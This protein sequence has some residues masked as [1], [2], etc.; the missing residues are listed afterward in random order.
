[1]PDTDAPVKVIVI[2]LEECPEVISRAPNYVGIW[3]LVREHG[4]PRGL[5]TLPFNGRD[6]TRRDVEEA[7]SALPRTEAK[8]FER[9]ADEQLPRISVV[10]PSLLRRP[11]TLQACLDSLEKLQYPD[12]EV[13]V[14]DNRPAGSPSVDDLPGARVVRQPQTGNSAARNRGLAAATGEI[15][16]F[17]DDDIEVDPNWLL[18]IA[19]RF[20]AH[21][22]EACVTGLLL[23]L[24]LESP[25][26]LMLEAYYGGL[27]PRTYEPVSHRLRV[28]PARRKLLGPA[29]VDAVGDDGRVRRS[30]SLYA[31]G[32]FGTGPN[33]AFRT[34]ALRELGGFNEAL[35]AG[36]PARGGGDLLTMARAVWAGYSIG[37]EPAA[38]VLH[39]HYAD[40]SALLRQI[41]S[42]GMGWSALVFA[43]VLEDPRHLGALL[44]TAPRAT[45]IL[46][47]RYRRKLDRQ[48][49]DP[50]T[51]DLARAELKAFAA[52]PVAYLRGRRSRSMPLLPRRPGRALEE[53]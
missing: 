13:I 49:S 28:P 45:R 23:P 35:G 53:T 18:A 7:I 25:A 15:V 50:V 6:L 12:Y 34:D 4:R 8:P 48:E 29:T 31:A 40:E 19:L 24:E 51:R 27:G 52:G 39:N 16:A 30:F 1:M 37:F 41:E 32:T 42:Y 26:Q 3:G 36:T 21:P 2:D 14:V 17:T 10:I 43:L 46:T 5:I 11:K 20:R 9:P 33:M 38:L 22:E 44:G 47:G